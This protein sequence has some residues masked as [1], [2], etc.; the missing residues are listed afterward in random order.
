MESLKNKVAI[1]TGAASEI[2]KA[3]A[4]LFAKEGAKAVMSIK[5]NQKL[6][7]IAF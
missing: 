2:G 1:I 6:K 4:L 5:V 3:T 7:F